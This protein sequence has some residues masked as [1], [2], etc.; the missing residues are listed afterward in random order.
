MRAHAVKTLQAPFQRRKN[1]AKLLAEAP[2]DVF[3]SPRSRPI[4]VHAHLVHGFAE[5]SHRSLPQCY[6]RLTAS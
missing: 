5:R 3:Q 6:I 4:C 2:A 1:P